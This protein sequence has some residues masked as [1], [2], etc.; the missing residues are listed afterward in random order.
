V[1]LFQDCLCDCISSLRAPDNREIERDA[2]ND[3]DR[4]RDGESDLRETE[5]QSEMTRKLIFQS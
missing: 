2:E 5:N 3:G 4:E 1:C